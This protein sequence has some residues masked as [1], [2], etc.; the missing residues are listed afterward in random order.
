M[1]DLSTT[2]AAEAAADI[3]GWTELFDIY[4]PAAIST[5]WGS[6]ATLRLTSLPGGMTF[7][8]PSADPEPTG[9]QGDA[10]AYVHWPLRRE[11]VKAS[12]TSLDDKLALVASNVTGEWATM[13]DAI[14]WRRAAVVIRKVPTLAGVD[15]TTADAV[16]IFQGIVDSAKVSLRS[17]TLTLSNDLA[18]FNTQLPVETFHAT[19]RFQ[20]GDDY[21][22][23]MRYRAEHY[24]AGEVASGSDR[25]TLISGDLTEDAGAHDSYGTDLVD[26]LSSGDITGTTGDTGFEPYRVRSSDSSYYR[27]DTS[28][29]GYYHWGENKQGYWRLRS[30]TAQEGVANPNLAPML[31]FDWGT[32]K[33]IRMLRL[34]GVPNVGREVLP[35]LLVLFS[36]DVVTTDPG[37]YN[38]LGYY[39]VPPTAD[40][41]HEIHIPRSVAGRYFR[42]CMRTRWFHG[43]LPPIFQEVR[44]YEAGRHYWRSGFVRFASDTLTTELR[45]QVRMVTGSYSGRLTLH[46]SLPAVPQPGDTFTI[47][48]G[49][50]R[51]WNACCERGN[52]RNFGGFPGGLGGELVGD[53][54]GETQPAGTWG[55]YDGG[56]GGGRL[57]GEGPTP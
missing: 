34:K 53:A 31:T 30:F 52:W 43:V 15:L 3:A 45:N 48:R 33:T 55:A 18:A 9:T 11:T 40:V 50:D 16:T 5:P 44:A 29:F 25:I 4:L 42:I 20:W 8:T 6:T 17:I 54:G 37:D 21:C 47:E 14:D 10:Q 28:G 35:R 41:L 13:L 36:S 23:Q 22:G 7:F 51:S 19:C 27:V 57:Y 32:S 26:A 46:R 12:S 49:C 39:E 1:T 38:H 24:K 2:V 56:D